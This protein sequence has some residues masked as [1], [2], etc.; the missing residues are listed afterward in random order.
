M[1]GLAAG[2]SPREEAMSASLSHVTVSTPSGW[3]RALSGL[4]NS[5]VIVALGGLYYLGHHTEWKLPRWSA[6]VGT[7][8]P[9]ADDW[10]VEHLVPE[11]ACVECVPDRFPKGPSFGF[12]REHGVAECVLHHP[13]LAQVRGEPQWPRY[14]TLQALAVLPRPENNSRNLLH[15]QRLQFAD[16]ESVT[17]AGIEVDVVRERPMRDELTANGELMFDPTRVAHLS[18]RVS[19][20][21]AVVWKTM[22]DDVAAGDLLALVDGAVVGQLKAQL[23]QAVVQLQFKRSTVERLRDV[24][25]AGVV[26]QKSLIEAEAALQ[27]AE[28]AY[29]AARQALENLGFDVPDTWETAAP[30]QTADELRFLGIPAAHLADL[31]PSVQTG[32]LI[33]LRAP[34]AGTIV[35]AD[36][37]PGE[38]VDVTKTLFTLADPQRLWLVLHVRQEEARY[39]RPELPVRFRPDDGGAELEGRVSWIS[40]V[41]DERTR[42]LPVRVLLS[43]VDRPLRDKTFGTG[44]I[45]LREEP[46]A[47]VVPRS[48]V[49]TTHDAHFVFVRNKEF[50]E[51]EAPKLFYVR[52]VRLGAQDDEYVELLAGVLPGEVVAAEG[53]SVLLAHLLRSSLGAGCGCH[54]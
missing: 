46:H 38:V 47:V 43:S 7:A 48:A 18:S 28:I 20:T 26:P 5:L 35:Q 45:V 22:G 29:L 12:C 19:G 17:R 25:R 51:D 2:S 4:I 53:S 10:C 32:N 50:F 15:K 3:R 54:E 33:P 30:R 41:I 6:I 42:T 31:P 11:S 37:V 34:L 40:P 13:E 44:R 23:L 52:Q 21:V 14:D 49:H 9:T 16:V 8:A 24:G 39:V 36:V 1:P 27:D